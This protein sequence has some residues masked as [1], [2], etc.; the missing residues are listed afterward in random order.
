[1]LPPG[2]IFQL[3]IYQ[4]AFAVGALNPTGGTYSAAPDP[5][6]GFQGPLHGK[7]GRS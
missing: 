4:N 3:K 7:G 5:L 2:A 1:M 6:A